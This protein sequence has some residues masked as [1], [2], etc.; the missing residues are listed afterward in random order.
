MTGPASESVWTVSALNP[1]FV[2]CGDKCGDRL[3]AATNGGSSLRRRAAVA[4]LWMRAA[5]CN[6]MAIMAA[7]LA[8]KYRLRA[9]DDDAD[10]DADESC[11]L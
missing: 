7:Y 1:D 3:G 2:P 10:A 9:Q 8:L 5:L 11:L 4:S 6:A